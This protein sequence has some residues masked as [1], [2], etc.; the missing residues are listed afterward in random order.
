MYFSG[1]GKL[2]IG[3]RDALGNPLALRFVGNVPKL[4]LA[5]KVQNIDHQESVSGQRA[6]DLRLIKGKTIDF[7][8]T[9]EDFVK[10]NLSLALYGAATLVAPGTVINEVLASALV[11]GDYAPLL[12]QN[13]SAVVVK[14]SA[15]APATLA[16]GVDYV[17]NAQHGSIQLLNAGAYVQPLKANYSYGAVN[18]INMFTQSLPERFIRFEGLNTADNNKPVLIELYRVAIDPLKSLDL[19]SDVVTGLDLS[20]VTMMDSF[21]ANDAVLGQF[22]RIVQI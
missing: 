10:E 9:M 18:N 6:T 20:G 7:T 3:S 16:A 8:C 22:G 12:H 11:A 5:P 1:Q 13:V 17:V 19:I 2:Y 14:D 4:Q 21:K 15:G